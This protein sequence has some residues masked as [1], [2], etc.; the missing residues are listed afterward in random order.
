MN[1]KS[2]RLN[3]YVQHMHD[4]ADRIQRYTARK[5]EAD[6]RSDEQLQDAVIRNIEII[7]EAARSVSQ[8]APEFA[9]QN[10]QVPWAALYAMRNR[11]SHGYWETDLAIV[12]QVVRRDLPALQQLLN[13]LV[14][15][16]YPEPDGKTP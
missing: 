4:A 14:L 15:S 2:L 6:F 16:D 10:T 3:D 9:Q 8:H 1:K 11:I 5:S 12:W 13:A 7:G